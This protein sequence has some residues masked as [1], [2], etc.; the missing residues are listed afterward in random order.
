MPK[1]VLFFETTWFIYNINNW[2]PISNLS[3]IFCQIRFAS[4]PKWIRA[5]VNL[6]SALQS[7]STKR[8]SWIRQLW[9]STS[10]GPRS[11]KDYPAAATSHWSWIRWT[12]VRIRMW[13][14]IF[15]SFRSSSTDRLRLSEKKV[16]K[17][18]RILRQT[19]KTTF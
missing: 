19:V 3:S 14:I 6:I 17:S 18:F 12:D 13:R 5:K 8:I 2:F 7:K 4:T 9:G 1:F 10:I 15:S 16:A 11:R